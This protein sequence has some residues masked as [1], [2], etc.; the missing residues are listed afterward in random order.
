MVVTPG[1]GC[2]DDTG[3]RRKRSAVPPVE[4]N[5]IFRATRVSVNGIV[6]MQVAADSL[7][8]GVQDKLV[9]IESAP[10][11]RRIRSVDTISVQLAGLGVRQVAVPDL[12]G[13]RRQGDSNRFGLCFR[14]VK[15]T[16]LNLGSVFGVQSIIDPDAVPGCSERIHGRG[17]V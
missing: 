9:R 1:E 8:I 5:G 15:K 12:V 16:K 6:P 14:R 4:T 17:P 7:R 13:Y 2:L 11:V 3:Q 10:F